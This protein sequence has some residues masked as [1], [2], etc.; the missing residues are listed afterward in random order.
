MYYMQGWIQ[1]RVREKEGEGGPDPPIIFKIH[2]KYIIYIL[3]QY[4]I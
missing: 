3:S 2:T 4:F 1:R